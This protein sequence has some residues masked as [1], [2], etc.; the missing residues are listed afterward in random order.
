MK[1]FLFYTLGFT[2]GIFFFVLFVVPKT[3]ATESPKII[4]CIRLSD[5]FTREPNHQGN[6]LLGKNWMNILS[7]TERQMKEL[8]LIHG[9]MSKVI[10]RLPIYN[11]ES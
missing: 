4:G 3:H 7:P 10:N 6:C 9:N 1:Q 2:I 8:L 5:N 11:A